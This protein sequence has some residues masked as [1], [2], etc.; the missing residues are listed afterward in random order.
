MRILPDN[1]IIKK[2]KCPICGSAMLMDENT[3]ASLF[4]GGGRKHCYDFSASGYVNLMPPGHS[5][6]GDG[7]AAVRARRDFLSKGYYKPAADALADILSERLPRGAFVIDAGCGEGYY[8]SAVAERGF[9]TA[10]VD[11]SKFAADAAA[12]R[13]AV[14]GVGNNSLF[15]VGSVFGLPLFDGSADAVTNIF[16]PCAE[17]EFCRVLKDCGILAVVYAGPE[18]LWGLKE[19]IYDT[20]KEN[21]GRADMPKNMR[22][23]EERRVRFDITVEGN[24]DILALFSMTP[25]YWRT[26]PS[27]SEKLSGLERLDTAVDMM[28]AVYVKE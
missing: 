25:Y 22:L 12:K 24:A 18:H 21:D 10:G 16:A 28:I 26:S 14:S 8:T 7:K 5:A 6:S 19:A 1:E 17:D 2:L 3:G 15:A 13:A 27:D 20:A 23:L 11:I 4:C 9:I